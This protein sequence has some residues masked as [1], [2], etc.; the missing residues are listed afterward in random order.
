MPRHLDKYRT[1]PNRW[2]LFV[3][4]DI[5]SH[6]YPKASQEDLCAVRIGHGRPAKV[7][8]T[9]SVLANLAQNG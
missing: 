6:Y 4:A 2:P 8:S 7:S 3:D 1:S 5:A 9:N